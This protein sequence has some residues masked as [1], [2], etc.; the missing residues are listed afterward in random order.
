MAQCKEELP[1]FDQV[2]T[3]CKWYKN[4]YSILEF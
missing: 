1:G 4:S 3:L 2:E